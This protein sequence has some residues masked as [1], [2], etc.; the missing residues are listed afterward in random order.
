MK[1]PLLQL[2]PILWAVSSV[3]MAWEALRILTGS[4]YPILVVTS[5]SMEP[6]FQRGDLIFLSN[7][8]QIVRPGDI[9]VIWIP[10]KPLPMVHRA[11][12]VDYQVDVEGVL[13]QTILT[14]GD[15]N[16]VDDR[17][18]YV[19]GRPFALRDEVVGLVKGYVPKLGWASVALQGGLR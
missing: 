8:Q 16:A 10:G 1:N 18:M 17:Y 3:F 14:K 12:T 7:R 2:F 11:I 15:N 13:K 19:P 6:A 9:P 4:Q 5:G